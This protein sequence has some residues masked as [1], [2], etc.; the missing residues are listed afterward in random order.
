MVPT[1]GV[2]AHDEELGAGLVRVGELHLDVLIRPL[3]AVH[4]GD[5]GEDRAEFGG[6]ASVRLQRE[7]VRRERLSHELTSGGIQRLAGIVVEHLRGGGDS[8]EGDGRWC[9]SVADAFSRGR[10]F[11]DATRARTGVSES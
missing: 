3:G 11:G 10:R 9:P 4:D 2:A 8:G 7:L 1:R 6:G 5:G